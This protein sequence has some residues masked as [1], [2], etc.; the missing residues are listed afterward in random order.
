MKIINLKTERDSYNIYIGKENLNIL[1]N[2]LSPYDKVLILSNNT[3]LPKYKEKIKSNLKENIEKIY[4]YEILDG[5]KYKNVETIMEI[6]KFI[7]ENNFS[8][9]SLIVSV[10]GGVVCDVGGFTV[11]LYMRGIDFIQVPTSLLSQ[12]DASIGGKTGVNTEIGKNLI[13]TFKQPKAVVIDIDFLKTLDKKEFLNGMGEVIKHSLLQKNNYFNFL[14]ENSEEILKL[15]E[16]KIIDMIEYS[17]N[18]KKYF[19]END[20]KEKGIRAYLNLG[21]TYSHTLEN[22]YKYK[23]ISHGEGVAKGIIFQYNLCESLGFCDREEIK[24]VENLFSKYGINSNPVFLEENRLIE[25]MKKDKKNNFDKINFVLNTRD[26]LIKKSMDIEK[27]K[28]I[29]KKFESRYIKAVIDIGTNSC[30]LFLAEVLEKDNRIYIEKKLYKETK[31]TKLGNFLD[32]NKNIME[33]GIEKLIGILNYYKNI[34]KK[35]AVKEVMCFATSAM[36]EANNKEIVLDK[37][38]EKTDIEIKVITGIEEGNITFEGTSKEF[39]DDILLMDIG[40]GSTEFIFGRGNNISYVKSFEL[41]AVR[42]NIKY[43]SD[44]NYDKIEECRESI[45]ERLKEIIRFREKDFTFV[46][47]AGTITT[48]VS[49]YEKMLHYDSGKVHLYVL[50]K[51]KLEENLKLYLSKKLEERKKIVGL[52]PERGD[53]IISGTLIILEV[54]DLIGKKEIVASE[55][56]GLEGA[57][58]K[59]L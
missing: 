17:C 46:G 31:I 44:D 35:S 57:I 33:E 16:E 20:E 47:V 43:F 26:G 36:R 25:V 3:I 14:C 2:Y 5:E 53:N 19:V 29:N 32:K 10:G 30:R 18:I 51:E 9:K 28:E 8:R 48:N 58:L 24:R 34:Y 7:G 6:I 54:M 42:E 55:C 59:K 45:R 4:F 1:N 21:H 41:G 11:S 12:V 38:K 13:G 50:T 39:S 56:D 27:I 49:V 37:I 15:S 22:I 52:Q 40:G 23:N